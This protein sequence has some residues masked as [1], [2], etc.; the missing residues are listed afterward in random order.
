MVERYGYGFAPRAIR[1]LEKLPEVV[2][3]A[4]VGFIAGGPRQDARRLPVAW[5]NRCGVANGWSC[6]RRGAYRVIYRLDKERRR[7]QVVHI[8]H[9]THVYC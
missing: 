8:D 1:D 6:G 9:R 3:V 5:A 2:A 7:L 4:C